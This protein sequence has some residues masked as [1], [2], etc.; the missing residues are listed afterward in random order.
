LPL[1]THRVHQSLLRPPLFMGVERRLFFV[2]ATGVA[3]IVGYGSLALPTMVVLAGYLT[4]SYAVAAR[5][6]MLDQDLLSLLLASLRYRDHYDP[7]PSPD[8]PGRRPLGGKR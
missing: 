6:S 7:L 3:P 8:T 2:I 5:L 4:V 1:E